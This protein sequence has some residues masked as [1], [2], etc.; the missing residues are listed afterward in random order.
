MSIIDNLK[1]E[2][3][4]YTDFDFPH[5]S[6]YT[7]DLREVI[8]DVRKLE[9]IVKIFVNT[10]QVKFADP[11]IWNITSQYAKTTVVLDTSGNAYLSKQAVPSGIQL[12]NGEYWQEIFNFTEYTRTAN[13]NLTV[14]EERN[15]TRAT[16]DYAVDDWLIWNDVLYKVTNIIEV[17]D[18]LVIGTNLVHFTVE[19]FIKAFMTWATN[20]IQQYK[21]EIDASELQYRQQLAQDMETTTASLQAQL[22][23][24]IAGA[25]VDSE[26]INA[27]IGADGVTYSTLGDAIRTQITNI[28]NGYTPYFHNHLPHATGNYISVQSSETSVLTEKQLLKDSSVVDNTAYNIVSITLDER[29]IYGVSA[30]V[31]TEYALIRFMQIEDKNGNVIAY[32]IENTSALVKKYICNT[33]GVLKVCYRN[34][35]SYSV[36]KYETLISSIENKSEIILGS[37]IPYTTTITNNEFVNANN[38]RIVT[39]A[40]NISRTDEISLKRGDIIYIPATNISSN[41]ALIA[42]RVQNP[43]PLYSSLLTTNDTGMKEHYYYVEEDC[44]AIF[45]MIVTRIGQIKIYNSILVGI[46][47][48]I[49]E[50]D[51]IIK[52]ST[53]AIPTK[54]QIIYN[55]DTRSTLGHIC[56]AVM[57]DDGVI[58]AAKSSGTI[59]R[60][61]NDGSQDVLLSLS[62]NKFDWRCLYMDSNENV[63]ASPHA[64]WGSM[65][66]TDRG[67][68]RLTKGAAAMSKV[69]SLY[70]PNSSTPSEAQ[71]NDDTIWTMCEDGD[72]NLYAGVYAHTMRNNP[73]IYKSTNG[74]VT[75]E[76]IFNFNTSGLTTAGRH[77]HSIIYS[78]WKDALYCIVGEINTIYKSTN[79]GTEWVNLNV[80]LTVKGTAML[81]TPFG[82]FIGS[83]GAYNCDID[84]LYNDDVTHKRV[85]RGWANTVFAI[86]RSDLT[87]FLYAFTKLDSSVNTLTYY[88]PVEAID[89]PTIIETWR[90]SVTDEQYNAWLDY[91][92]SV[93]N[94]YPDDAIRPQ[95]YGIL[96]SRDGG[97]SW[98][99]LIRFSC[100]STAANGLWTTGYFFNGECLTGRMERINGTAEILNPLIISEGKHKYVNGGCDLDGEILVRTNVNDVVQIL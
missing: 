48:S 72:G 86:R 22:N 62:G 84:M 15:T 74:G 28:E 14:N 31:G 56:N 12:N 13:Q 68:Y 9:D 42:K 21:N 18:I 6:L 99:P 66:M 55:G 64:A 93:V 25:T 70:N 76:Y 16:H 8:A 34:Y 24:A 92:N 41:V 44:M 20:T 75:W 40:S 65:N 100:P 27:R 87:G 11:I 29:Y 78:E 90:E 47:D 73:A 37:E 61:N 7:S 77:I 17:D 33:K 69:I 30:H 3:M 98:K 63:Y 36:T 67:L 52:G 51:N 45:S 38:G 2:C 58:I 59:I 50:L 1:G 83:D 26:V 71:A 43:T 94:E 60:I 39:T 4:S 57:Y 54:G 96:I 85:F 5:T 10:E 91:H 81:P 89:D 46:N 53:T 23:A 35:W 19:D 82:I 95:H 97:E 32:D 80:T 79:G 88:P 49:K